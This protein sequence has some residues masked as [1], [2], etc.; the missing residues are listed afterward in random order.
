MH[1]MR[2][3]QRNLVYIVGMVREDAVEEELVSDSMFGKY[4]KIT[5]IVINMPA[6]SISSST[7]AP[8][9]SSSSTVSL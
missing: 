6:P 4:G 3:I 5:K 8:A 1:S 2:I 7:S 9:P